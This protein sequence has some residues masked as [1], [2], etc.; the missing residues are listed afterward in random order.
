M[1]TRSTSVSTSIST[2]KNIT[3]TWNTSISTSTTVQST[4]TT[5]WDTSW[6]TS[7]NTSQTTN[8]STT[9]NWTTEWQTSRETSNSPTT[10]ISTTTSWLTS[11]ITSRLTTTSWT[12]SRS[13]TVS[14]TGSTLVS[15]NT[16]QNTS[17]STT[18]SW[19]TSQE[20]SRA[21]TTS[22]N[23]SSTTSRSTTTSWNTSRSTSGGVQQ[24]YTASIFYS[25]SGYWTVP[26]GVYSV[27]ILMI[28]GGGG[29]G[30]AT[31]SYKGGHGG[32]AG[33]YTAVTVAVRPGDQIYYSVGIGGSGGS[34][35]GT[36]GTPSIAGGYYAAGG[37]GGGYNIA[38]A[39]D[40][41]AGAVGAGTAASIYAPA[42]EDLREAYGGTGGSAIG[43]SF[44]FGG[45]SFGGGGGGG[46]SINDLGWGAISQGG[47]GGVGG[48]GGASVNGNGTSA[49]GNYG[50]GGGGAARAVSGVYTGGNGTNGIIIFD[51]KVY[52][53]V[54]TT[55]STSQSTTT[56]WTTT[57][58]TSQSTT[59]SWTSTWSTSQSTI[60]SWTTTW[61]TSAYTS[62]NTTWTTS[63][64]TSTTVQT[65]TSWATSWSVS[66][67]TTTTWPTGGTVT[68]TTY[69]NTSQNTSQ[70]TN[71]SWS[72]LVPVSRS[73]TIST[74]I[75]T[76]GYK[77]KTTTWSTSISTT[78]STTT[79]W[80]T[81]WTTTWI[82]DTGYGIYVSNP[83]GG[84]NLS[85]SML[86]GRVFVEFLSVN[87]GS[88]L[89]KSYD[90]I[91]SGSYLKHYIISAGPHSISISTVSNKATISINYTGYTFQ[92]SVPTKVA[93][94]TTQ[95]T[96]PSFGISLINGNGEK[97]AST[98]Y[99]V[100]DFIQKVTFSSSDK[101]DTLPIIF[102]PTDRETYVYSKSISSGYGRTRI[103]MWSIPE[104]LTEYWYS[105]NAFLATSDT[106]LKLY[107]N[108]PLNQSPPMPTAYIFGLDNLSPSSSSYGLR[109]FNEGG[110]LLFDSGL[111]HIDIL[112]FNTIAY[113]TAGSSITDTTLISSS[114]A[115]VLPSFGQYIE[116]GIEGQE[117]SYT[118][119]YLGMVRRSGSTL[120]TKKILMQ[121]LLED[122]YLTYNEYPY[123]S[124][125]NSIFAVDTGNLN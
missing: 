118:Y 57:W 103:V 105:G 7:W 24:Q 73:T 6:T 19:N 67:T 34:A 39:G 72:T 87:P 31:S 51:Y 9:T 122:A 106:E 84:T 28:G 115:V 75:S 93:I 60:T 69:W 65:S 58:L 101:V 98:R 52:N 117:A 70:S 27:D 113:A 48:G 63:W 21:T 107:I 86:G 66:L 100:P 25:G 120:Y 5:S 20:Y 41:G 96:E 89:T 35:S 77:T 40:G 55:W 50:S 74:S 4:W 12:T 13:T 46:A 23:T 92:K 112:G 124:Q 68:W 104:S 59:T 11:V 38:Y 64:T 54:T 47:A 43:G 108:S 10:S 42:A 56:S 33:I 82:S 79:T 95:T 97:V 1:P 76:S 22:W 125:A 90:F 17:Q 102:E 37:A 3:T 85:N 18:T 49:S 16:S 119:E 62:W 32:S 94:F 30:G 8:Q 81:S 78:F 44:A 111:N 88:S 14:T 36:S 83:A 116:D 109:L 2:V 53:E 26:A 99:P 121:K 114:T 80:T 91:P 15:W 45:Y 123:G 110:N 61:S 71:T 29:G